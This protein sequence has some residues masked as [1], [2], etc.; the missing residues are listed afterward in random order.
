[1]LP[2]I[3]QTVSVIIR[4]NRKDLDSF[5]RADYKIEGVVV[6]N[7]RWLKDDHIC[8]LTKDRN[9]ISQIA[10]KNIVS[11]DGIQSKTPSKSTSNTR[12]YQVKSVKSGSVYNVTI[13]N[14]Q[15]QC[16]CVGFQYRR[17]CKHAQFIRKINTI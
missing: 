12:V 14:D 16:D 7:H 5:R 17:D 10:I 11:I 1:M 8:V 13:S 2:Q 9:F 6:P 4:N 15:V 3:G